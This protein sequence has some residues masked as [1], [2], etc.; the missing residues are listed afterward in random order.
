MIIS[1]LPNTHDSMDTIL[2]SGK[3]L[4]MHS[5][6]PPPTDYVTVIF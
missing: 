6:L 2:P 3:Q 5:S 1:K 4:P